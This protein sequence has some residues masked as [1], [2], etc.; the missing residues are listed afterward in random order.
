M[1]DWALTAGVFVQSESII[2]WPKRNDYDTD[3]E[4]E[5]A[6]AAKQK[7]LEPEAGPYKEGDPG[8]KTTINTTVPAMIGSSGS[9]IF[10]VDG[11]VIALLW[12]ATG[13]E[14]GTDMD[15][16][17]GIG[18][19]KDPMPHIMHSVPVRVSREW[20]VGSPAW[21]VKELIAKWLDVKP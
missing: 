5:A 4:F 9:P 3:A 1:G 6:L 15:P 13:I 8:T 7:L 16:N 10:N 2:F 20:T 11:E 19:F 14:I 21:K 18:S 17:S 12:G